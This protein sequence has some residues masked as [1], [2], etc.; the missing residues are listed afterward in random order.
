M[1]MKK[2]QIAIESLLDNINNLNKVL[3]PGTNNIRDNL[4]HILQYNSQTFHP[5]IL[6]RIIEIAVAYKEL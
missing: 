1:Q 5:E 2:G 6:N 3:S 4:N